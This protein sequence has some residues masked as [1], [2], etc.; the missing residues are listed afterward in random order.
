MIP[1]PPLLSSLFG[2]PS[3][4]SILVALTLSLPTLRK[5]TNF[6]LAIFSGLVTSF[7]IS[8]YVLFRSLPNTRLLVPTLLIFLVSIIKYVERSYSLFKAS[9]KGIQSSVE[10]ERWQVITTAW[11]ELLHKGAMDSKASKHMKQLS[12]GDELLNFMWFCS[13]HLMLDDM[14]VRGIHDMAGVHQKA[15]HFVSEIELCLQD[16]T[17]Y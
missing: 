13:K 5:I 15:K 10:E 12:R 6:G 2:L 1:P 7:F 9:I 11:V 4:S 3:S 17:F 8:F 16:Y 14:H